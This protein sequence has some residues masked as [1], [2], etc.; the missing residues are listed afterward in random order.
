TVG[1]PVNPGEDQWNVDN[2]PR[3]LVYFGNAAAQSGITFTNNQV[4]GSAGGLDGNDDA[5][6]NTL[7]TI[8][9]PDS[10]VSGNDFSGYT[11]GAGYQLRTRASDTEVTDNDFGDGEGGNV[12]FLDVKC[13]TFTGN[14]VDTSGGVVR[15]QL[16]GSYT[17]EELV[18]LAEA[19]VLNAGYAVY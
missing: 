11:T 17:A 16:T 9:V 14:E 18:A 7:V 10:V 1:W 15:L 6:G 19:N 2:V 3:G 12:G 5:R 13:G 4:T 8:D